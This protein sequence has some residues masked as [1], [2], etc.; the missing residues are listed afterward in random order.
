MMYC[1]AKYGGTLSQMNIWAW[2]LMMGFFVISLKNFKLIKPYRL[3]LKNIA[4][5]TSDKILWYLTN[6][7]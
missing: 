1:F 4:A 2:Q 3:R 6:S 5:I 7:N